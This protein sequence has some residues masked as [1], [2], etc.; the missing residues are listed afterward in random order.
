MLIFFAACADS[1]M[2]HRDT[3]LSSLVL[4]LGA[5]GVAVLCSSSGPRGDGGRLRSLIRWE[6]EVQ[7]G[8]QDGAVGRIV[9]QH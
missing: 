2:L 9:L 6:N 8:A 3:L 7:E 5:G 1:L 4:S